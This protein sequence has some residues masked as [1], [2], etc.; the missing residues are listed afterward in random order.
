MASYKP[1]EDILT[2]MDQI[3]EEILN[4]SKD[5]NIDCHTAIA[6]AKKCGVHPKEVGT[7][8]DGLGIRICN[9]QLGCFE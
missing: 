2:D 6:I 3:D 5:G 1:E 9:C 4:H 7:K 8:L